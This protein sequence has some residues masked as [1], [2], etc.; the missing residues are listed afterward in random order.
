[1]VSTA[2]QMWQIW[3]H[4]ISVHLFQNLGVIV[5]GHV[6]HGRNLLCYIDSSVKAQGSMWVPTSG[7]HLPVRLRI[8]GVSLEHWTRQSCVM[9]VMG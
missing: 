7:R 8:R 1:M 5:V 4:L 6:R 3:Q 9:G 2:W